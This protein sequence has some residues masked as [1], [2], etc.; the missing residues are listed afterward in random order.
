MIFKKLFS[1]FLTGILNLA[2][3]SQFLLFVPRAEAAQIAGGNITY[4]AT[5]K[6]TVVVTVTYYTDCNASSS[7]S[8]S[9]VQVRNG[10]GKTIDYVSGNI[11][12]GLDITPRCKKSCN[13]CTNAKCSY[14]F[15]YSQYSLS[16]M[17]LLA[18]YKCCNFTFA[19][20]QCCRTS[21]ITTGFSG[22]NFY[23]E[24]TLNTCLVKANNSP[25][26]RSPA[27]LV[28][29]KNTC[30]GLSRIGADD[31]PYHD[32]LSYKLV[33]P[34]SGRDTMVTYD[35]PYNYKQPFKYNG[36]FG[37]T[38]WDSTKCEG[39]LYDS[40]TGDFHF[41]GVKTDITE[42][43]FKILD[44]VIDSAGKYKLAGSVMESSIINFLDCS[45]NRPSITNGFDGKGNHS[46]HV[47]AGKLVCF[48]FSTYDPDSK[49]STSLA[50]DK[51]IASATFLVTN[52]LVLNQKA[53]FCWTPQ[54][55]R[56]SKIPYSFV[57]TVK[58]NVCPVPMIQQQTFFIY[59]DSFPKFKYL[60][61]DS[62]CGKTYFSATS[63]TSLHILYQW[64]V[65]DTLISTAQ[66][67]SVTK[68][69][70]THTVL[71][72]TSSIWG[73]Q[74]NYYYDTIRVGLIPTV[75]AGPDKI[76]CL[77]DSVQL[78]GSGLGKLHW[79]SGPGITKLDSA[80]PYVKPIKDQWYYLTS[81]G[82]GGCVHTDSV[83]VKVTHPQKYHVTYPTTIC[84]HD[85]ATIDIKDSLGYNYSWLT[86]PGLIKSTD[87]KHVKAS[88]LIN[89][90]YY[91]QVK[92]TIVG[93]IVKD[94][95]A[96]KVTHPQKYHSSH[97]SIICNYDTA[98]IDLNDSLGYSYTWLTTKSLTKSTD[99]K[100][101]KAYPNTN[102]MYYFQV[103]DNTL[104][105]KIKDSVWIAVDT[106]CVYPGDANHDKTVNYLDL[107][108]IAVGI[109][110]TGPARL[111][112]STN[113]VGQPATNW[114]KSVSGINYK[115]VDCDGNGTVE[116]KDTLPITT[117]YGKSHFK[118]YS[119][120]NERNGNPPFY[121]N[122]NKAIYY[123]G[124]TVRATLYLGNASK[125]ISALGAAVKYTFGN[126]YIKPGSASFEFDCDILCASNLSIYRT[127][128]M[129][130][131]EGALVRT[132][133]KS[134]VGYG[135]IADISYILLDT[136][137]IA[138]GKVDTLRLDMLQ[139]KVIDL[140]GNSIQVDGLSAKALV[141]KKTTS[142][143]E[144]YISP[145]S[146]LS[147][148]PNPFTH[149]FTL[150]LQLQRQ[151][152]VRISCFDA[153]GREVSKLID[154]D[155]PATSNTFNFQDREA[156][157]S[158]PGIYFI[159]VQVGDEVSVMRM[160]KM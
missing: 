131:G 88:P 121:F 20:E 1:L 124:D 128:H 127:D 15:G 9:P 75:N 105:C 39:L 108:P 77:G 99:N 156:G 118:T 85:T 139:K 22:T 59:V 129:G 150:S 36:G 34:M 82:Y 90:T 5:G 40:I 29:C 76:V 8:A 26:F 87:N 119:G 155:L 61:I 81:T 38:K 24:S 141:Y 136:N 159:K 50:W 2:F 93:C 25:Y 101:A 120:L 122:F 147:I 86:T 157:I 138:Y 149:E 135:K 65:N 70:G 48:N 114:S 125:N 154:K 148:Y 67:F 53:S 152:K 63:D 106:D 72:K 7:I 113:W 126:K 140:Q 4:K 55:S 112:G 37:T 98:I 145:I 27:I 43:A 110:S 78:T 44:W 83:L 153:L 79:K 31:D 73:Q 158:Q 137:K 95:L 130:E 64:Y 58:D 49:D 66:H 18:K 14:T 92:D 103:K 111:G 45:D 21:S 115:H 144:R 11:A 41:K 46:V 19:W 117:N 109:S 33:S 107:L 89:T 30:M 84:L 104:G 142:A 143:V 102:T 23:V 13:R 32:S 51:A 80:K 123:A 12:G 42:Y 146:A 6:D 3:I 28:I 160:V 71:L 57:L 10:C 132:D 133:H 54:I 16:S 62:G 56:V 94:S 47:F 151:A 69:T 35:T 74:L 17:V 96:I 68:A 97:P 100:H 60:K 52:P 134:P 91:F 116:Y